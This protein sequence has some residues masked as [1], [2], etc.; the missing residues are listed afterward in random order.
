MD[1]FSGAWLRGERRHLR[2]GNP[3][4]T[5][6]GSGLQQKPSSPGG[7]PARASVRWRGQHR[8]PIRIRIVK[9]TWSIQ[10]LSCRGTGQMGCC[11]SRHGENIKSQLPVCST[12]RVAARVPAIQSAFHRTLPPERWPPE[13]ARPLLVVATSA[14]ACA[15]PQVDAAAELE[16]VRARSAG[17]VAAELRPNLPSACLTESHRAAPWRRILLNGRPHADSRLADARCHWSLSEH[18][19]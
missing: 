15:G 6:P 11:G 5:W 19:S 8:P 18:R 2:I 7:R 1:A 3:V 14:V 4:S 16:A 12:V 13:P 9:R 10:L 17:I